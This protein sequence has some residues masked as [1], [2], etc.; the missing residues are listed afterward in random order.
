MFTGI[1]N[2]LF[3][4]DGTLTDPY[5]GITN[6][7][8]HSLKYYPEIAVPER[9]ALKPFIGPPLADSYCQYFGM[10]KAQAL[11]AVEHYREYYRERGIF[12]NRLY[13]GIETLL[14]ALKA[15][16]KRLYLAT[17][18]PE[19]FARQILEHFGIDRYFNGVYGSTLDGS[20]VK[21]A[22]IITRVLENENCKMAETLMVGDTLYDVL[23]AEKC[24]INALGV[25][26]GYGEAEL[27]KKSGAA[28]VAET[29][30]ELYRMLI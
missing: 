9:E 21:K 25:T 16:G 15:D 17:S 11:E 5:E 3:D 12:E 14:S 8:I 2:I 6:S 7:V 24:G 27:L 13:D 10:S 28:A 20:V 4:L 18:K 30:D 19:I 29:V 22:D 23:G 26:Y 1:K